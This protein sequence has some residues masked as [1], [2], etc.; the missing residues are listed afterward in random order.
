[1]PWDVCDRGSARWRFVKDWLRGTSEP[2]TVLCRRHGISR[3]C[4]YKWVKRFEEGGRCGLREHS[5]L[6]WRVRRLQSKWKLRLTAACQQERRFG[7]KKLQWKLRRDYPRQRVP[8]VRT[9]MR[10]LQARGRVRRQTRRARCGPA[11][12]LPGRLLGRCVNDVWTIDLKGMFQTGDGRRIWALTVRDLASRYVLCVRHLPKPDELHI[13]REMRRLFD[14]Y[15]LPRAIRM[16]N[17][18]PFGATGPRGWSCLSV[19]WIKLGI[20]TEY[21]RPRHPEDNPHHEQMHRV[22]KQATARPASVN[23]HAQQRRFER[24]RRYYNERR[25]HEAHG[26][27]PPS[28]RY[29][30]SP[31][32]LPAQ[33]AP[34]P[35]PRHWLTFVPDG[36]GRLFW[37]KRQRQIGQAFIGE[38][39]AAKPSTPG[40][41]AIYFRQYLIGMLHDDDLAGMRPVHV[42][43][44]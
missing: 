19:Q 1:M 33:V 14:Q 16:D 15:G 6:S 32:R 22:L 13:G 43:T 18:A 10:W 29:R 41:H 39:L 30:P 20:Q 31:R 35:Y 38:R 34:W 3:V 7:P 23:P 26:Q 28:A 37:L 17:G 40:I 25:P 2:F 44:S 27:V 5:R 4:G 21:G 24:W 36:K 11:V 42:R 8:A 9:L 12:L